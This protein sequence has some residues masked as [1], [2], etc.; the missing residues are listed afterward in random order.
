MTIQHRVI[1]DTDI[2]SDVDDL[3]ALALLLGTPSVEL[4]G[5]TTVYGD[6]A[7]R[8]RLAKRVLRMVGADVPVH[9]GIL[10][11]LSGRDVWWAGHE[12]A[13]YEGLDSEPYDSDD[14]VQYLIDEVLAAPGEIDVIAIGPLTNI[15]AA[16]NAEPRFAGAVRQLWVMGGDFADGTPEHNLQ[17]DSLAA[18][19]V[20]DSGIPVTI[21]GLEVTRRIDIRKAA[22]DRIEQS[23]ALGSLIRAEIEQWW[24]FWNEEW[25]VPHD[26]ITVLTLTDPQ[27][28]ETS[29]AG[30][31]V[32]GRGDSEGCSTYEP[33]QGQTRVVT[34]L[35]VEAVTE[36][37]VAGIIA[38]SA[39]GA[40]R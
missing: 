39:E 12:G 8:A 37:I 10:L 14:A 35:D 6:T 27:L 24:A 26:P 18:Q 25:N 16:I 17:S 1:L 32:I 11:P 13:L 19:I 4:V 23:G 28:F 21:T 29:E 3:M 9:A 20:F 33:G 40:L 7:L 15:A 36:R 2:G 22:L 5:V 31:V 34:T 30:H 38:G